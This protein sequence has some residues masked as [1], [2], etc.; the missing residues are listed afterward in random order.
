MNLIVLI[1]RLT[2]DPELKFGQS[3]KAYCKLAIA[4]DN[5]IK[6]GE[7]DFI[8]CSSFGKT[9]ELIG[10]HMRKGSKI[11]VNGRLSMS[12]YEKDGEKRTSYEVLI[13]RIEFLDGKRETTASNDNVD[14][15]APAPSSTPEIKAEVEENYED[16]EFP[17]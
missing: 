5:P 3:G 15:T 1:G 6:K 4:V 16:D 12:R 2:R 14:Y 8:N 10:E 17:F 11:G 13:D 9:A 7:A